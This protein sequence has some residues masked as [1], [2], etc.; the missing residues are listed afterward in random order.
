[1]AQKETKCQSELAQE[2]WVQMGARRG[3]LHSA[4]F[5][6]TSAVFISRGEANNSC[7]L[8]FE[9][10]A[11]PPGQSQTSCSVLAALLLKGLEAIPLSSSIPV[12]L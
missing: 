2:S 12:L 7:S 1:M 10:S 11:R 9:T 5:L 3:E 8:P 4:G 6:S